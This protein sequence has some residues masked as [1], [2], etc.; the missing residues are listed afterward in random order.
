MPESKEF[1][2]IFEGDFYTY[3]D[4]DTVLY[5]LQANPSLLMKLE[6]D[7]KEVKAQGDWSRSWPLKQGKQKLKLTLVTPTLPWPKWTRPNVSLFVTNPEKTIKYFS[8]STRAKAALKG[9]KVEIT[10]QNTALV[11]RKKIVDLPPYT[12]TVGL[13]EKMN[14]GFNTRSCS[15]NGV[16][17]GDL[18][19]IGPNIK[20]RGKD[21]SLILGEWA[22]KY[23]QQIQ[24]QS[25]TTDCK[26]IKYTRGPKPT[27]YYS[28]NGTTFT[29][30]ANPTQK[31]NLTFTY[32][33]IKNI[34]K[35]EIINVKLPVDKNVTV[36]SSNGL[37]TRGTLSVNINKN[38]QFDIQVTAKGEK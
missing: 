36:T 25:K 2:V 28:I 20:G 4:K 15:I 38:P 23:P 3:N 29:L 16:W 24:T 17:S 30:Q 35:V 10:A 26:F 34:N 18:L 8:A 12:I 33:I 14:Y 1:G 27:F 19:N 9:T 22:F 5:A 13:P 11:Q 32:T 21:G 31:N 6:I 7:G 37:I